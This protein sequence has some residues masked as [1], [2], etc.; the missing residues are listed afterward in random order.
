MPKIVIS[1]LEKRVTN[2]CPKFIIEYLLIILI[3]NG[4]ESH[5]AYALIELYNFCLFHCR[6]NVQEVKVF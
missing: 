2:F 6:Q 3:I 4:H 5:N 1:G